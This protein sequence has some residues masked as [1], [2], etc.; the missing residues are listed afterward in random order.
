MWA[1]IVLSDVKLTVRTNTRATMEHAINFRSARG[2]ALPNDVTHSDWLSW[3]DRRNLGNPEE[4]I[5]YPGIFSHTATSQNGPTL[6]TFHWRPPTVQRH[7]VNTKAENTHT[8]T[9]SVCHHNQP[10]EQ[11]TSYTYLGIFIL[12][13]GRLPVWEITTGISDTCIKYYNIQILD[14]MCLFLL[15]YRM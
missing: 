15:E 1:Y 6:N 14:F 9:L 8:A 2:P 10:V 11:A 12:S 13:L 3:S 5:N 4:A 7:G